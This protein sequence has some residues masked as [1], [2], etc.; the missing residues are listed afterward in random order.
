MPPTRANTNLFQVFR[1][2][3]NLS[4]VGGSLEFQN[5]RNSRNRSLEPTVTDRLRRPPYSPTA[6]AAAATYGPPTHSSGASASPAG[7]KRGHAMTAAARQASAAT[8]ALSR[9]LVAIASQGLRTHCSGPETHHYWTATTQP[10][11]L[12]VLACRGCPVA[13][14]CGEAA[15]ANDERHGVWNGVDRTVHPGRK[16]KTRQRATRSRDHCHY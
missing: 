5:S 1:L 16:A 3:T 13:R 12:A 9:A 10:N 6:S 8:E 14:E 15:E 7:L 2:K 4:L 11:A